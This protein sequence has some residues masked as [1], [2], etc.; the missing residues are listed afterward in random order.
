MERKHIFVFQLS[1]HLGLVIWIILNQFQTFPSFWPLFWTMLGGYLPSL[2][3]FQFLSRKYVPYVVIGNAMLVVTITYHYLL[4]YD[5]YSLFIFPAVIS[6]M[7]SERK[8][9][10]FG[11]AAS[12]A[13]HLLSHDGDGAEY[14]MQVTLLFI[15]A[16]MLSV[17]AE[18]IFDTSS[19]KT[20]TWEGIKAFSL[21]VEAKDP[22]TN[23][24][25]IRVAKY[26]AIL[27]RY[28]RDQ[29]V[30]E[31][32]AKL[33]GY[34]HDIGKIRT[35]DH[36][37]T[38]EGKLTAEEFEIIKKHCDDGYHFLETFGLSP[39]L[40]SGVRYHHERWDGK[41]YPHRLIGEEIPLIA[42]IIAVADTFDAITTARTY[43]KPKPPQWAYEEIVNCSGKQ[44]DPL[45]VN[46][47]TQCY[48]EFLAYCREQ[49]AAAQAET[50]A[51]HPGAVG[52]EQNDSP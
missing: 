22:Y 34:V 10:F 47:F 13:G 51:P 2:F 33:C 44:F 24:H 19:K 46:V 8:H 29:E 4:P 28:L 42:R 43:K 49:M 30:T 36:I 25:S 31:E 17:L 14:V 39:L 52:S 15:E 18:H 37:L 35:P 5:L 7:T 45:I 21:A 48:P 32:E 11:L 26:A 6:L 12:F 3:A 1:S 41:G 40:L 38:K 9:F 20:K 50:P 16:L 23:G 27:A